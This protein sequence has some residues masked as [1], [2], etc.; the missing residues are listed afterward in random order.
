MDPLAV[1]GWLR[2]GCPPLEGLSL[3]VALAVS[4]WWAS[5]EHQARQPMLLLPQ[6]VIIYFLSL[7]SM[8]VRF[9]RGNRDF[10]RG[11]SRTVCGVLLICVE[12]WGFVING[13]P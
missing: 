4:A 1:A 10:R 8:L 13:L 6:S 2:R 7:S 12:V 11:I 5:T 3:L 9:A